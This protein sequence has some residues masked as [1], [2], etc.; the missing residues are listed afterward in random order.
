MDAW[1][2]LIQ[3]LYVDRY[4]V[5]IFLHHWLSYDFELLLSSKVMFNMSNQSS[6]AVSEQ[7]IWLIYDKC[8]VDN[9]TQTV[10]L[11]PVYIL[12]IPAYILYPKYM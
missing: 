7:L 2:N 8:P 3:V 10:E 4:R 9:L 1:S 6:H 12:Y 5:R 11:D